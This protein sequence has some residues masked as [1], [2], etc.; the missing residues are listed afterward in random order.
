MGLYSRHAEHETAED[1][2]VES[3]LK[4]GMARPD[5]LATHSYH[6]DTGSLMQE[7]IA[8]EGHASPLLRREHVLLPSPFQRTRARSMRKNRTHTRN[9][10]SQAA[11]S[12]SLPNLADVESLESLECPPP[13]AEYRFS[14]L[15]PTQL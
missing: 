12:L 1:E 5:L 4:R 14:V 11:L 9:L 13:P 2:E 7:I 15:P 8:K 3:L 6:P 10:K